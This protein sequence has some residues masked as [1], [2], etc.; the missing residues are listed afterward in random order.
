MT[1]ALGLFTHKVYQQI[2]VTQISMNPLYCCISF[3]VTVIY[4]IFLTT[5]TSE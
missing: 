5:L 2:P 3:H 1:E 4:M